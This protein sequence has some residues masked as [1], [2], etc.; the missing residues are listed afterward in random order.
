MELL[1]LSEIQ[2]TL[3]K[4]FFNAPGK[5][6]VCTKLFN[7]VVSTESITLSLLPCE[8]ILWKLYNYGTVLDFA[9]YNTYTFRKLASCIQFFHKGAFYEYYLHDK[10]YLSSIGMYDY[11]IKTKP[12]THNITIYK[13]IV[14]KKSYMRKGILNPQTYNLYFFITV[15]RLS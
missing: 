5:N 14:S 13:S 1:A 2:V 4:I 10:E 3:G 6:V 7:P 15:L 9:F 12:K 8:I 11:V